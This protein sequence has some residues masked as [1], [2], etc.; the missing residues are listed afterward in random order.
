MRSR[1][2]VSRGLFIQLTRNDRLHNSQFLKIQRPED[3]P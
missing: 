2:E 3:F 1:G